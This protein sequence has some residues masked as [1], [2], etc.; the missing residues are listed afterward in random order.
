MSDSGHDI[1]ADYP[2]L[3]D[4]PDSLAQQEEPPETKW[5][6][7]DFTV[8]LVFLAMGPGFFW[9][10]WLA[11]CK[12]PFHFISIL[13]ASILGVMG[14]LFSSLTGI[15]LVFELVHFFRKKNTNI[16]S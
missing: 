7:W 4:D 2:Y 14:F 5:G 15:A 9:L 10:A 1:W 6:F 3:E 16:S 12:I 11:C 13:L 8:F